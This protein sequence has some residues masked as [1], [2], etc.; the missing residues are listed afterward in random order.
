VG[1]ELITG[2]LPAA[3]FVERTISLGYNLPS[4]INYL[5]LI[6]SVAL[7][8]VGQM[9]MKQGMRQFGTFAVTTLFSQII[10]MFMNPFVFFGFVAFG[11]SSIFW[12]VVLSR[13]ELSFVY[14]LVSIAY[15][16][17]A[18]LSIIFFKEDVSLVRWAGILVICLGVFLVSRS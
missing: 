17:V 3:G 1:E 5:L 13:M 6:C 11:F 2:K 14:P 7:A 8:V 15:I 12:L 16:L 4:M 10:P 9:L 18:I